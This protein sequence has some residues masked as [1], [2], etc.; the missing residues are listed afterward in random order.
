MESTFAGLLKVMFPSLGFA[1]TSEER[2]MFDLFAACRSKK[3]ARR[4]SSL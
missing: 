2:L 4:Q 3:T 1:R